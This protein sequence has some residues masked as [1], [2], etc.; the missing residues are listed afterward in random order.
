MSACV[1]SSS[2]AA[3]MSC[4]AFL[5]SGEPNGF[6]VRSG[7]ASPARRAYPYA[8]TTIIGL[9]LPA[10]IRLSRMKFARPCRIQPVSSSPP[11][12]CR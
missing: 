5:I 1:T 11:P 9:Q 3:A 6:P 7:A 4:M 8:I 12:C 10:A 2:N